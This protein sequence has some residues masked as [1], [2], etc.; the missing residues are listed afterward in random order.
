MLTRKECLEAA[1]SLINGK[2]IDLRNAARS[3]ADYCRIILGE[4]GFH[5]AGYLFVTNSPI[6]IR[7]R[8]LSPAVPELFI[9]EELF[10]NIE[11]LRHQVDHD[12]T[13]IPKKNKLKDLIKNIKELE[14]LFQTKIYP[15]LRTLDTSPYEHLI[16]DWTK[17]VYLY[18]NLDNYLSKDMKG[19]DDVVKEV[20]NYFPLASRFKELNEKA[21]ADTRLKLRDLQLKLKNLLEQGKEGRRRKSSNVEE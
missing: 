18:D 21:I 13:I 9:F 11:R 4:I 10:D 5:H 14:Q 8:L 2:D 17:V 19:F 15:N 7:Y 20:R 3:L 12:D 1:E 6:K 16:K